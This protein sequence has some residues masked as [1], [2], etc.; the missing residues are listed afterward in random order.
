MLQKEENGNEPR[1]LLLKDDP[2][3]PASPH[4]VP[5]LIQSQLNGHHM[6]H[7]YEPINDPNGNSTDDIPFADADA[8]N[9]T[10]K[11]R[12]FVRASP[13]RAT[14]PVRGPLAASWKAEPRAE[15][16]AQS[17]D[18]LDLSP[19]SQ[20][21]PSKASPERA[22]SVEPEP[23]ARKVVNKAKE[24]PKKEKAN[25]S[26][27]G[28][29]KKL[30]SFGRRDSDVVTEEEKKVEEKEP[31]SGSVEEEPVSAATSTMASTAPSTD[32]LSSSVSNVQSAEVDDSPPP[33]ISPLSLSPIIRES[34]PRKPNLTIETSSKDEEK[35][36]SD[37]VNN[38]VSFSDEIGDILG[39]KLSVSLNFTEE[40]KNTDS[41]EA[42][43]IG[44][45]SLTDEIM[46]M[47]SSFGSE[48]KGG[49]KSPIP[50][51]RSQ[52][53]PNVKPSIP[54]TKP[55]QRARGAKP[56]SPSI[57]P[58][59]PPVPKPRTSSERLGELT[60]EIE[61]ATGR[62]SAKSPQV[63]FDIASSTSSPPVRQSASQS[64]LLSDGSGSS[65]RTGTSE[66]TATLTRKPRPRSTAGRP[67]A[68]GHVKYDFQFKTVTDFTSV[69]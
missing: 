1:T 3:E 14:A 5:I 66:D 36:S 11:S 52:S 26:S 44:A 65:G 59:S 64:S 63:S 19:P 40:D 30:F 49:Q 10:P 9:T 20:P 38:F 57:K 22:E 28:F 6:Q 25:G 46:D 55:A 24:K 62:G 23:V 32:D 50:A 58:P 18:H 33:T 31:S 4:R 29:F 69:Y 21:S 17:L 53:K 37:R 8:A 41:D 51:S 42:T 60:I 67:L 27:G 34:S 12:G 16:R 43:L 54:A 13:V 2:N 48:S 39:E 15:Q 68:K 61:H 56:T 7:M 35:E 47:L 45:T